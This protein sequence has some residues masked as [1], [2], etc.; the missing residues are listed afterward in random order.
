M[1]TKAIQRAQAWG[2]V[3][4]M[5]VVMALITAWPL[6][7]TVWLSLT[8]TAVGADEVHW[9][10]LGNYA[11]AWMDPEFR[12]ALGRT[13]YFTAVSVVLEVLAG[14]SVGV[15]LNQQFKGRAVLRALLILPWALPTIVNAT[16][17]RLIFGPE[18]GALNAALTQTG[19]MADY[20]SW[21]GDPDYAIHMVILADAWKNYPFIAIIVLAALQG[22]PEDLFEAAR[23]DG[24]TALQRFRYI[25]LPGIAASLSV[26]IVLR[27]IDAFKV[28]DILY[29]MTKGGPADT[30]KTMSFVVYQEA[31][32]FLRMGSGAA[33]AILMAAIA[34]VLITVYLTIV[35]RGNRP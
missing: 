8:D 9:V 25:T 24:A 20:T 23:I 2:L 12:A 28:F 19:L 16:M 22:I 18:Y 7:K 34:G 10:W 17:W 27:T 21:L 33:Y 13:L 4:P 1:G 31:F 15:L 30:T 5:L 11:N 35:S 26:A 32:S 29:V 6:A 3:A 14:I